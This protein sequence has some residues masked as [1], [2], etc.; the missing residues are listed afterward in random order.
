M[1]ELTCWPSR[2]VWRSASTTRTLMR[3]CTCRSP[4][5]ASRQVPTR[6]SSHAGS[7]RD[8]GARP[9]QGGA[10]SP[11]RRDQRTGICGVLRPELSARTDKTAARGRCRR[12]ELPRRVRS[13]RLTASNRNWQRIAAPNPLPP[14]GHRRF[15]GRRG[16]GGRAPERPKH[17]T[18][19]DH[20]AEECR[21]SIAR[22]H[23]PHALPHGALPHGAGERT[24]SLPNPAIL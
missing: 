19:A 3:R 18:V 22:G 16:W 1:G 8:G 7:R 2:R 23:P 10:R 17:A 11:D 15:R 9:P 5:C 21:T 4:S 6:R 24:C 12:S 13:Q 20:M 14:P